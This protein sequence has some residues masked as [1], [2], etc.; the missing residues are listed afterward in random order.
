MRS[1]W[2]GA[3]FGF[4]FLF[5]LILTRGYIGMWRNRSDETS[6]VGFFLDHPTY[7]AIVVAT[8]G[9]AIAILV[10]HPV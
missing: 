7:L 5:G 2:M 3:W 8:L 6:I 4:S 1:R 10:G 9:Q